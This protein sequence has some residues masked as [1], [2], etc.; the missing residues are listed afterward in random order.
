VVPQRIERDPETD[1]ER[2]MAAEKANLGAM[3]DRDDPANTAASFR[4]KPLGRPEQGA[5]LIA[6]WR[7]EVEARFAIEWGEPP[8][9]SAAGLQP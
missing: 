3:V 9:A 6:K 4:W 8:R 1:A 5:V 7:P 2:A